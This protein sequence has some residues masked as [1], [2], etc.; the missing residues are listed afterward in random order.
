MDQSAQIIS[1]NT[2]INAPINHIADYTIIGNVA[3][4]IPKMIKFYKKNSK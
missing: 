1:I 2:D 3:D 4:I